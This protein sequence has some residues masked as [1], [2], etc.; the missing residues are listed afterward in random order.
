MGFK[1]EAYLAIVPLVIVTLAEHIGDHIN[2]GNLTGN[3]F[4][5]GKPGVYRT[6][7]GDGLATIFSAAMGGPANTSYGENTSVIA[8]TK[9]ASV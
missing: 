6:L 1:I 7:I 5:S 2:I 9:V 8:V 4:I 3:D